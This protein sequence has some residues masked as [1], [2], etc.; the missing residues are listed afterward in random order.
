[1]LRFLHNLRLICE[2]KGI[3]LM[4]GTTVS[5]WVHTMRGRLLQL[6]EPVYR[7]YYVFIMAAHRLNITMAEWA[8]DNPLDFQ[9]FL[10][11]AQSNLLHGV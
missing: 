6:E 7:I 4:E 3:N 1:M 10:M 9:H 5:N 11:G 8:A 2:F